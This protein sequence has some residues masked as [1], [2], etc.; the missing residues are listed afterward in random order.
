MCAIHLR[1]RARELILAAVPPHAER[2]DFINMRDDYDGER[3]ARAVPRAVAARV[4]AAARIGLFGHFK[5][6]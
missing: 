4:P 3:W 2:I 1:G 6:A 5:D